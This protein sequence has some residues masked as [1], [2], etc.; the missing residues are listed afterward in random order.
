MAEIEVPC[1]TRSRHRRLVFIDPA[2]CGLLEGQILDLEAVL[3]RGVAGPGSKHQNVAGEVAGIDV[4]RPRRSQIRQVD[5]GETESVEHRVAER[6]VIVEGVTAAA[7]PHRDVAVV[8]H[9][10]QV[11]RVDDYALVELEEH[12]VVPADIVDG[13]H[14]AATASLA[15]VGDAQPTAV[16]SQPR[17]RPFTTGLVSGEG[18][19]LDRYRSAAELADIAIRAVQRAIAAEVEGPGGAECRQIL[20]DARGLIQP[21]FTRRQEIVV[22]DVTRQV[23]DLAVGYREVVG[24]VRRRTVVIDNRDLAFCERRVAGVGHLVGPVDHR[25]GGQERNARAISR[26]FVVVVRRNRVAVART[27]GGFLDVDSGPQLD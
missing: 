7:D 10:T 23:V 1:R 13:V 22:S 24:R 3:R 14:V 11:R 9:V 25:A 16:A 2:R 8:D 19:G 21:H 15:A 6:E 17:G 27:V 4:G 26:I 12:V 20:D 18:A 5:F